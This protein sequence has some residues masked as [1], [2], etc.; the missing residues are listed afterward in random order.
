MQLSGVYYN[1]NVVSAQLSLIPKQFHH[2]KR[3][4]VHM[5]HS[6]P[7]KYAIA[8]VFFHLARCFLR[9]IHVVPCIS[10]SFLFD[11]WVIFHFMNI[12]QFAYPLTQRW[13]CELF[14]HFCYC[15]EC[16]CEHVHVCIFQY[17]FSVLLG[18]FLGME[19]L[20]H[21]L[22][23]SLIFWGPSKVF[24]TVA[25]IFYIPTSNVQGL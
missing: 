16:C 12:P 6:L 5:K 25:A 10:T 8:S 24:S 11:S 4:P 3:K 22:I 19:L 21:T 15:K 18:I 7:L 23:L 9:L 13:T 1:H 2:L 17:L 14:P 20:G